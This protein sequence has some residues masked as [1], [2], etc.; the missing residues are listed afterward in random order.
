MDDTIA[1]DELV[2]WGRFV[3]VKL[4]VGRKILIGDFADYGDAMD[5][6]GDDQV[7]VCP[8]TVTFSDHSVLLNLP[9]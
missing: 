6:K 3:V 5:A 1:I 2:T 9:F 4:E 7:V 8:K